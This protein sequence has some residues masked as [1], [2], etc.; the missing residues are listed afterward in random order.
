MLAQPGAQS[1]GGHGAGLLRDDIAVSEQHQRRNASDVIASRQFR[2][3]FGVD[4]Q[5]RT[6][7]S[8]SE[9]TRS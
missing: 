9:V 3:G 7:G 8:N 2:F 4:L 5:N 6:S 1:L